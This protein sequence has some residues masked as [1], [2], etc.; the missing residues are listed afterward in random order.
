M[1]Y[2]SSLDNQ[3]FSKIIETDG[4]RI[5]VSVYSYNNGPLKLQIVRENKDSEGNFRF[6]KLG[7]LSKEETEAVLPVMTEALKHM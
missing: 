1:P 7:R 2:D 6:A 4:G 5:T 3:L